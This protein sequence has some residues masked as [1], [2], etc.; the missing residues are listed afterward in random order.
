MNRVILWEAS[1]A[2]C[3]ES[4]TRVLEPQAGS[5]IISEVKVIDRDI[6]RCCSTWTLDNGSAQHPFRP[7]VEKCRSEDAS[8][9]HS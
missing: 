3:A 5:N 1:P 6:P 9:T 4:A 2:K 7:S 8:L